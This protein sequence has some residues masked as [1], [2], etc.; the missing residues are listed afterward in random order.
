[1]FHYA[2]N[3]EVDL[4]KAESTK[5]DLII[6]DVM[7]QIMDGYKMTKRIKENE[8]LKYTPVI[9]PKARADISHKI[10]GLEFGADDYLYKTI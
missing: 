3:G 2:I 9:M 8:K 6:T 5:H 10:E 4:N 7:M 1:M